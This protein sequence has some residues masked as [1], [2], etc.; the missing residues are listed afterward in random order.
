[1][2]NCNYIAVHCWCGIS[3]STFKQNKIGIIVKKLGD[4][5]SAIGIPAEIAFGVYTKKKE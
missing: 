4:T 1:M 5:T 3:T 2:W